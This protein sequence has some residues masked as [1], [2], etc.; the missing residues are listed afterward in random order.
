MELRAQTDKPDSQRLV[1]T[2]TSEALSPRTIACV[3]THRCVLTHAHADVHV[4]RSMDEDMQIHI[5]RNTCTQEYKAHMYTQTCAQRGTYTCQAPQEQPGRVGQ[6]GQCEQAKPH[7]DTTPPH[8][9]PTP[10]SRIP[11]LINTPRTDLPGRGPPWA[12]ATTVELA[13]PGAL[14]ILKDKGSTRV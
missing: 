1:S 14:G 6:T 5:G 12:S 3:C 7:L 2:T 9:T 13:Q 8:P 4:H 10:R 11:V